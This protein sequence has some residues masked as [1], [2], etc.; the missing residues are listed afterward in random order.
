MKE[1]ILMIKDIGKIF[2][3][4]MKTVK[5]N[6]AVMVVLLVIILLPSLYA[7]LNIE[8][9]WDPYA[10]TSNIEVAVVNE[11]LGYTTNGTNYNVGNMLVDELKN[12]TNFSWQFVDEST[13]LNGV[14]NG[15]YYAV[16]I[17]P[18]NFSQQ[19][20]SIQTSNPQQAQ[21][22]YIVNDKTNP[23]APRLTNA[24]V[25][26]IQTQINDEV[27][28][29]VDGIIFGKLSDL[30]EY[31]AANKAEFLKAKS[32][33]N[34]LNGK[35]GEIDSTIGQANTDINTVNSIWP[36]IKAALPEIQ[37]TSNTVRTEYDSLYTQIE[38]NPTKALTNV[39]NM[40]LQVNTVI[41][42]L[43]Y[44]DAILT[45]LYD[46]TGD[47]QL[48]P[49]I[50][51][52]E[53]DINT[54]NNVLVILKQVEADIKNGTNPTGD[55]TKL[56]SSIDTMDNAINTLVANEGNIDKQLTEAS[57]KL[58]L[59]NTQWP[60]IK[61]AIPVAAAKLNSINE[62]D[63]NGLIA[64]SAMNQT[65]VQNYFDSPVEL[66]KQDMYHIDNYGSA[67]APFYISISLWIGCIIA[68]AMISMRVKSRIKYRAESIYLG[69][70]GLFIVISLLQS[71]LVALGALYLHV[72][73]TSSIM[74]VFTTLFIG[75]CSMIIV[76]SL[77]SAIG[78]AGKSLAIVILVLQITATGGTFP[79]QILP[80]FFQ[81][82]HPYLPLTYAIG[83]LR[84]VIGGIIWSSYWYNILILGLFAVITL[85]VTLIIKEKLNK[86]AQWTEKRLEDSGLF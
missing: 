19:L 20:L 64:F 43:K 35:I 15:K 45:S 4:D 28:K 65:G 7:L 22:Q 79:V 27:V 44:I 5:N 70:M 33:V 83:A 46:T 82:I 49:I 36:K 48:K 24:G 54:A 58:S 74:F 26:A 34:E 1:M 84:E 11:D 38:S 8:A 76:Y 71:I 12:N 86:R 60:T 29:T 67:L 30:G 59:V 3:K 21:I 32:F 6:P 55:L 18:S 17:I 31:A 53:S 56:K 10:R 40:E 14:K 51:Q 42:T 16:L 72:Q 9:T 13:G 52:V 50:D 47:A 41:T 81:A 63:I 85:V 25:D 66:Q 69:R 73:V 57:A 62:S 23:I 77:T 2:K 37:K 39:Q 75:L 61:S 68:A 80:P 78:N